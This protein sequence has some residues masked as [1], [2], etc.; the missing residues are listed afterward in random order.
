MF[1][2]MKITILSS[3][4]GYNIIS[5]QSNTKTF[6]WM[7][8]KKSVLHEGKNVK[9]CR[10]YGQ[11]LLTRSI[12][13]SKGWFTLHEFFLIATAICL[14]FM[15][16]KICVGGVVGVALC[17]HFDLVLCNPFVAIR[18]IAVAIR[19]KSAMRMS[20]QSKSPGVRGKTPGSRRRFIT[21]STINYSLFRRQWVKKM[22][23]K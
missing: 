1:V 2:Q 3:A 16:G 4:A 5:Y 13:Q 21:A 23:G 18:G 9:R 12:T 10:S 6:T 7:V 11:L 19:K 17:E 20:L 22:K 8:R 14:P 15:A